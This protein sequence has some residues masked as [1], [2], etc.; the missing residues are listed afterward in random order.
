[1][2]ILVIH[3]PH[4]VTC[5]HLPQSVGRRH[6][7]MKPMNDR[8]ATLDQWW[9]LEGWIREW[10]IASRKFPAGAENYWSQRL[11]DGILKMVENLW[12]L[13]YPN[14]EQ[15][16]MHLA[17]WLTRRFQ[18]KTT[19][20]STQIRTIRLCK[21]YVFCKQGYLWVGIYVEFPGC[22]GFKK[23]IWLSRSR[24]IPFLARE[25]DAN[26]RQG[27]CKNGTKIMVGHN[28]KQA[29]HPKP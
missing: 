15:F 2:Y 11:T 21:K 20:Y 23:E 29:D 19:P 24:S 26:V 8:K 14:F 16:K 22:I 5:W 17:T 12:F 3:L 4:Q 18:T 27:M 13:W 10:K 28:I 25:L 7:R 6:K 9:R 1:M